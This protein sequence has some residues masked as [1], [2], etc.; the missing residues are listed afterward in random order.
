MTRQNLNW[1]TFADQNDVN[2]RW[3]HPATPGYYVLDHKGV[4][5]HK[6]SGNPGAKA[7]DSALKALIRE[8][9]REAK[10]GR[11]CEGV[12]GSLREP[13]AMYIAGLIR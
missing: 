2:A 7:M 10:E 11:E 13:E 5:R 9:E 3:N 8:A 1:R 12:R 4:I 6:W